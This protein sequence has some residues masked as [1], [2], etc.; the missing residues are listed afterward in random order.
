MR[1]P[2]HP[3]PASCCGR[4]TPASSTTRM[5]ATATGAPPRWKRKTPPTSSATPT[6][7]P[8]PTARSR[9]CPT[10]ARSPATHDPHFVDQLEHTVLGTDLMAATSPGE[11][12]RR[13]PPGPPV[14]VVG[15]FRSYVATPP[16]HRVTQRRR[17]PKYCGPE[18]PTAFG[19][20]VPGARDNTPA[21]LR[22]TDGQSPGRHWVA[23]LPGG[24]LMP[25][26]VFA[27]A[28]NLATARGSAVPNRLPP[29]TGRT[30]RTTLLAGTGS[31]LPT[32]QRSGGW[33]DG[34]S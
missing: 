32:V 4:M 13:P 15:G 5:M 20:F 14:G 8:G 2:G 28:R 16:E 26:F 22:A 29:L 10:V 9:R 7:W 34:D 33:R 11:S 3:V 17:W 23:G 30:G 25:T 27:G 31:V 18:I 21:I 6:A 19:T 24:K 12:R 1:R